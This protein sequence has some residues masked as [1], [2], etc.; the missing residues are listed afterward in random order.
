VNNNAASALDHTPRN[1]PTEEKWSSHVDRKDLVP[2]G[3]AGRKRIRA[4]IPN[5]GVVNE[6]VDRTCVSICPLDN[7]LDGIWIANVEFLRYRV[8]TVR[9]RLLRDGRRRRLDDIANHDTS[10]GSGKT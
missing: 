9:A 8:M 7:S 3:D 4:A 10:T 2:F 6:D 5:T 1:S